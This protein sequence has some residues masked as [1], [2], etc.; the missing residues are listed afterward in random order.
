[1]KPDNA[2]F[3]QALLDQNGISLSALNIFIQV[4]KKE[5]ILEVWAKDKSEKKFKKL[6]EYKFCKFSG[7]LGPKRKEGDKQIPEGLYYINRFNPK[8]NFHLSLGLNYPNKSDILRGDKKQP[9]SDIF[10]HGGCQTIGCIPITN[11]KIEELYLLAQLARKSGQSN[12]QVHIYPTQMTQK[13][14]QQIKRAF[15]LNAQFWEELKPFF[16]EFEKTKE[17]SSFFIDDSGKY[18]RR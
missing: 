7:A 17:I 12:I 15:P 10:I 1:M 9:G 18:Q 3:I 11:E 2:T 14:F 16:D 13:K 5:Q 8:S 4:F 6:I